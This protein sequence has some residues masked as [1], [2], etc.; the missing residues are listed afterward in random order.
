VEIVRLDKSH[1]RKS[2][3]CGVPA[4]NEFLQRYAGQ[5][6]RA[7]LSRTF[8][9]ADSE[10]LAVRGYVTVRAGHVECESLPEHESKRLPRYPVPVLHVARLAVDN[11][12]KGR[13][14]GGQL[15][16]Y[17]LYKSLTAAEE[18]GVWAVEVYAKDEEA[19]VFH[20][21]FGFRS[22]LDDDYHLYLPLKT[23]RAVLG[24]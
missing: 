12:A 6:E 15:L 22:L 21:R 24:S 11:G 18:I 8:V 3:D 9:V 16:M 2:F 23:V 19:R 20:A 17:A 1:R 5:N 14:I 13:G 10:S 7:G 4:L